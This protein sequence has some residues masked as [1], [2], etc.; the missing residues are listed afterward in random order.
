MAN[1]HSVVPSCAAILKN[2]EHGLIVNFRFALRK[3]E[4]GREGGRE[5]LRD[6]LREGG[7]LEKERV[8]G[9]DGGKKVFLL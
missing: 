3:R 1:I 9:R 8:G 6:I 2:L 7:D 5:G 4:G